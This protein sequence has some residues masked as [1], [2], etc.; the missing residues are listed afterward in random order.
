MKIKNTVTTLILLFGVGST[1]MANAGPR[2]FSKLKD[3]APTLRA[4][5]SFYDLY[6]TRGKW[7]TPSKGGGVCRSVTGE[8][9]KIR[10]NKRNCFFEIY[11]F[12]KG[13]SKINH[14]NVKVKITFKDWRGK[15]KTKTTSVGWRNGNGLIGGDQGQSA[16][17]DLGFYR[18]M[19]RIKIEI[20][21][22][23]V[24][25]ESNENNNTYYF[26]IRD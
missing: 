7:G 11:I 22:T 25:K 12:N 16:K 19:Q 24:I 23:N 8:S 5:E 20:D 10:I 4:Q 9:Y 1:I 18:L 17:F 15:T 26:T 13:K 21:S 3:K 6:A 2:D 14:R